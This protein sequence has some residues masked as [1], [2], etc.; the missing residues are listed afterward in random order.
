V[1]DADVADAAAPLRAA[2]AAACK[3][4]SGRKKKPFDDLAEGVQ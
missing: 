4:A 2:V 1:I 3:Q